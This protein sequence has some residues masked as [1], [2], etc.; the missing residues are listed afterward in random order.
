[1]LINAMVSDEMFPRDRDGD[2][3]LAVLPLFHSFGQ[4]AS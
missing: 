2:V 1:M 4:T 3:Y